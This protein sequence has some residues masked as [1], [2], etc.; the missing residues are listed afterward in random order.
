MF[1]V[2]V[3]KITTTRCEDLVVIISLSLIFSQVFTNRS[4]Y[5]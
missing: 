3:N 1:G 5:T 2:A 4:T